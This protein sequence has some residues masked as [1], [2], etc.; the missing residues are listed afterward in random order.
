MSLKKTGGFN[1]GVVALIAMVGLMGIGL[2]SLPGCKGSR[3]GPAPRWY[4]DV[5]TGEQVPFSS[6]L[7]PPVTLENG[8]QAVRAHVYGCG[9]CDGDTFISYVER[10][11]P[12]A[13]PMPTEKPEGPIDI[14]AGKEL[15]LSP[16]SA[17]GKLDWV[18][19]NSQAAQQILGSARN[20]C[21]NTKPKLCMPP[22]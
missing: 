8:H 18:P 9:N 12:D 10:F 20:K 11:A 6:S 22:R 15:A 4:Y 16:Q 13:P 2:S 19:H 5:Q 21:G 3:K 17:G 14:D 7:R 1:S